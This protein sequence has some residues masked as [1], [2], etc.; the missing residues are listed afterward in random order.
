MERI[1][2]E[3]HQEVLGHLRMRAQERK[4]DAQGEDGVPLP[5]PVPDG[6]GE[7]QRPQGKQRTH[8]QFA[9]VTRTDIGADHPGELIGEPADHRS[10]PRDAQ[11]PQKGVH[12]EAGQHV[13]DGE[14]EI[15]RHVGR[16]HEAQKRGGIEDVPVHPANEREPA[17]DLGIPEGHVPQRTPLVGGPDPERIPGGVLIVVTRRHKRSPEHGER[18][19]EDEQGK[20]SSRGESGSPRSVRG[21]R[22][23]GGVR[24]LQG[25]SPLS[26]TRAAPPTPP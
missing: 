3:R 16:E 5:P 10:G 22:G 23:R 7:G 24:L 19:D 1:D 8:E 25:A 4:A 20:D 13:M 12:E 18:K 15:H 26:P 17:V 11:R 2:P 21:V 6:P 14:A 9:V